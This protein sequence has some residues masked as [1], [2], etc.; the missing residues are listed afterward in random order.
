MQQLLKA[1]FAQNVLSLTFE[2]QC[3][4]SILSVAI[5]LCETSTEHSHILALKPFG[6]NIIID[7]H[8]D[9]KAEVTASMEKEAVKQLSW[10]FLDHRL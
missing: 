4:L 5:G 9:C 8:S 7:L 1:W 2:F 6:S 3:R 10:C